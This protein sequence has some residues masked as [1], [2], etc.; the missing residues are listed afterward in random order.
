MKFEFK[1]AI[2]YFRARRK[3]LARFTSLVAVVGIAAGVASLIVAQALARGFADEMRD[4]ILANTAHVSVFSTDA[5]EISG[6]REIKSE[7]EQ[8]ENVV[9]IEP[10]AYDNAVIIGETETSYAILK[11]DN[12]KTETRIS[13]DEKQNSIPLSGNQI[14]VGARLAEKLN[15][16]IGDSTEIATL[17]RQAPSRV[18]VA[19]I[20]TTGLYDYDATWIRVSPENYASLHE[21]EQFTP[22]VLS[23]SV[24]DIY[25]TNETAEN[26]RKILGENFRIVDWQEANRPLFAALSLERK[27]A[28]AVI[29]LIIFVAALNITTTLALLVSERRSDIAVLRTCGARSRNLM[30]IFL[31]EGIFLGFAGIFLGVAVGLIAC[32][33]GNYFQV[34]SLSSE[35][36]ALSYVPLRPAA[37]NVL[38]VA[39]AAFVLCLLSTVYPAF[40]AGRVKPLENLRNL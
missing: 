11:V 33:A 1:L 28:F 37:A 19:E 23:V 9:S 31:L 17:E 21:R 25:R 7:L 40:R 4:K 13:A 18:R 34:V 14:A 8:T 3:S 22:S 10:T 35:V 36:Y 27:V 6:W 15:L 5:E 20:F 39:L 29:S 2:R 26:I 38:L 16:K 12:P 24:A 30:T 32:A